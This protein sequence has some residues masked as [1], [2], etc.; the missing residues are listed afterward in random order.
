M[1]TLVEREVI[2]NA[3]LRQII[4][5]EIKTYHFIPVESIYFRAFSDGIIC[6]QG[7]IQNLGRSFSYNVRLY[8]KGGKI[9]TGNTFIIVKPIIDNCEIGNIGQAAYS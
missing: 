9:S 3:V 1:I 5:T 2:D 4:S 6:C 8:I 7:T